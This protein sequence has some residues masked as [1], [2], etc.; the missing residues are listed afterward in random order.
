MTQPKP[1]TEP[2]ETESSD[3]MEAHFLPDLAERIQL[4]DFLDA[5]YK[6]GIEYKQGFD[7]NGWPL[8]IEHESEFPA[9]E[10]QY[11]LFHR[12]MQAGNL[13]QGQKKLNRYYR[14]K[15]IAAYENHVK[16]IVDKIASYVLR[17][18]PTRHDAAKDRIEQIELPKWIE[19][20]AL[21]SL[22]MKEA[23]IGWDAAT[24]PVDAEITRAQAKEIDPEFEGEPYIVM[25]DPR[26]IVD[27]EFDES[28]DDTVIR[29]VFEETITVKGGLTR[30]SK[31]ITRYKEWDET[32]WRIYERVDESEK[33]SKSN[34]SYSGVK[35][36]IVEQ[37]QHGFGV[38]PWI[39]VC[40]PFPV[41]DIAELNR[42]LFNMN[43]LLD[44]ELYNCTFT[45]KWITG[46]KPDEISGTEGGTGNTIVIESPESNV[47][48]FGA[49]TGQSTA[50]M[51]RV[52]HLRDA[53]YM[54]VSMENTNTKN[55][56]ETA[57]KK[58]RDLESLYT[59]LVQIAKT[60]EYAE[61]RLLIGMGIIDGENPDQF[62]KYDHRFD[63]NS[64]SELQA[65]IEMLGKIPFA[66]PM[67]KRKLAE[68]LSIKLDPFGDQDEYAGEIEKLIDSTESFLKGLEILK[69]NNLAT[70]GMLANLLGVPEDQRTEFLEAIQ[71]HDE[72]ERK[73]REME[74][75][76]FADAI[77]GDGE[78]EE[79]FEE[80]DDQQGPGQSVPPQFR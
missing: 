10:N 14:R 48:T 47:G 80:E 35:V 67:L 62:T 1:T 22:R 20:L 53:I 37:H 55:V 31:T 11:G 26:R 19:S 74:S 58:K 57:D 9:G 2:T 41:E 40:P 38:C 56:A 45:Q 33:S 78:E 50:L 6:G 68:Q 15:R 65:D 16:P 4:F 8:L 66:P 42:A 75:K 23:W 52:N 76:G 28:D 13:D 21:E 71:Q 36:R 12:V 25:M 60:I 54:L 73:R 77:G 7:S 63:V 30:Q 29:V 5:S 49:V 18:E 64:I 59:M 17:N 61:N 79:G 32:H 69:T 27:C 3:R 72:D 44:E 46:A 43:S 34:R 51:E 24:I 39:K 70:P